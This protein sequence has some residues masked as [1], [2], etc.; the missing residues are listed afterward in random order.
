MTSWWLVLSSGALG[1]TLTLAGR[2]TISHS[3]FSEGGTRTPQGQAWAASGQDEGLGEWASPR[4]SQARLQ[5]PGLGGG[6]SEEGLGSICGSFPGMGM[7]VSICERKV[8]L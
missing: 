4:C 7:E 1:S 2:C 5:G 8:F 3:P 6:H